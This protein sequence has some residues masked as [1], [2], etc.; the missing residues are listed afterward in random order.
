M[1]SLEVGAGRGFYAGLAVTS[2]RRT[3]TAKKT[4]ASDSAWLAAEFDTCWY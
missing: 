4:V 1:R 3:G 2:V